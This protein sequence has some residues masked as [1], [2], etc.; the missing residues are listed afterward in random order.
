MKYLAIAALLAFTIGCNQNTAQDVELKTFT[1]SVSYSIGADI[2]RNFKQQEIDV[3]LDALSKG[4]ADAFSEGEMEVSEVESAKILN[5]FQQVMREKMEAKNNTEGAEN[6]TKGEAF[7]KE[8]KVKEGVKVTDSGL[9]YKVIK[10]G[11]GAKPKL[12]DKVKVHYKGTLLDGTEFDSS[13]KRGEP[14]EFPLNGVIKG[15][16]EGITYFKEGGEGMLLI[17]SQLGYGSTDRTG[18]PG[19]SVLLFDIKLLSVN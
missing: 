9:Q 13:Y 19:G 1:D 12:T 10:Q 16:T 11:T 18:I 14:A 7:L 5:K 3:N 8:N 6:I 17:P 15:W 4:L 2:G